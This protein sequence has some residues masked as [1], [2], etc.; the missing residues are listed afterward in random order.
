VHGIYWHDLSLIIGMTAS[1]LSCGTVTMLTIVYR[2]RRLR[3][4]A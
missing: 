2:M 4:A 1:L 3:A